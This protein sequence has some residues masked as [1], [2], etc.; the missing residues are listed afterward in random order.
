M[1]S[2]S[3]LIQLLQNELCTGEKIFLDNHQLTHDISDGYRDSFKDAFEE[4]IRDYQNK[5]SLMECRNITF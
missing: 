5:S 4:V 1:I 2:R 3:K